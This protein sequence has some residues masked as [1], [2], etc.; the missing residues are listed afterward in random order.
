MSQ[1]RVTAVRYQNQQLTALQL[2]EGEGPGRWVREPH[3]VDVDAVVDRVAAGDT[4]R[5]V[6]RSDDRIEDGPPLKIVTNEQGERS[7]ALDNAPTDCLELSDLER[8]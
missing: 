5:A 3:A 8:F 1:F 7:L 4:V 2:G 6:L